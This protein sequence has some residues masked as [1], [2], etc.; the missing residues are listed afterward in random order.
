MSEKFGILF[1]LYKKSGLMHARF[2]LF[3]EIEKHELRFE[4]NKGVED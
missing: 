4:K 1:A 2:V 3:L